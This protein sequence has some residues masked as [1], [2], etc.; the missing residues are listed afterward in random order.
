MGGTDP[1]G[2]GTACQGW[3]GHSE[4]RPEPPL[5]G[6]ECD[7]TF[8]AFSTADFKSFHK[9]CLIALSSSSLPISPL[10]LYNIKNK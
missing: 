3:P 1:G 4:P 8:M 6:N 2:R 7:V 10:V 9:D 5:L